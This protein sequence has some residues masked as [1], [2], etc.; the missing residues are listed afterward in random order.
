M[1][2]RLATYR[3]R[4]EDR[5][6][7]DAARAAPPGVDLVAAVDGCRGVWAL[8]REEDA[9]ADE[10]D[11]RILSLWDTREEAERLGEVL[12]PKLA[13]MFEEAGMAPVAPP[14]VEIFVVDGRIP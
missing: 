11:T 4:V 5:D 9:D 14:Q 12:R 8:W 3:M 10:A 2:G 13:P 7:A 6:K 1:Y